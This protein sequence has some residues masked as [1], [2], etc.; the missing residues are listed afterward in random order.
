MTLSTKEKQ[1]RKALTDIYPQLV[2]N[3][4]NVCGAAYDRYGHD[5]LALAVE[6]FL[7]KEVDYQLKVISD[8]KL[9]NYITK[10]MNF[11][12]KLSTTKF[13]HKYRKPT[14]KARE[15]YDNYDYGPSMVE[16]NS[17]FEDE[18]SECIQCLHK[19]IEKL[20]PYFK[21]LVKER[22]IENKKWIEITRKYNNISYANLKKDT[23]VL[24][25]DLKKKCQHYF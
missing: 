12:L 9:E 2:I 5:L 3:A 1:V 16:F 21:M 24:I 8:G 15:L 23:Q 4:R 22:V 14:E 20:D 7:E 18:Q 10:I 11:Q 17:A 13:Y 25:E 6:F 19:E